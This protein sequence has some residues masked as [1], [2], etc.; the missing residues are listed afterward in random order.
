MIDHLTI[1]V[2]DVA[3]SKAF[4]RAALAPLGY[5]LVREFEVPGQGSILGFGSPGKPA[6]W[7]ARANTEHPTPAGMHLALRAEKRA[8]VDAFHAAALAAGARDDGA[9]GPRPIYHA[10]YYGAF[11]IDPDGVR[12]EACTHQPE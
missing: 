6:L 4:Y 12:L 3:R 11:V 2:A 1:R 8:H 10:N 9:P 5:E 7:F